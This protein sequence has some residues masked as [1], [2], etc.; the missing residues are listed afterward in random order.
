MKRA[1]KIQYVCLII[2]CLA[3]QVSVQTAAPIESAAR[4]VALIAWG[5][6]LLL[7]VFV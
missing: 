1:E 2:M 4:I 6:Y 5:I 7:F 3:L